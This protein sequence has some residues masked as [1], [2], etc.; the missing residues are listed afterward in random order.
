MSGTAYG[1]LVPLNQSE[2][3]Y[4]FGTVALPMVIFAYLFTVIYNSI[5]DSRA[6]IIEARK[7]KKMAKYYF[8]DLGVNHKL[9]NRLLNYLSYVYEKKHPINNEF[10]AEIPPSTRNEYIKTVIGVS[11]DFT[12]FYNISRPSFDLDMI[13]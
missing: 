4:T 8:T 12:I 7:Y 3:A 6:A 13:K 9:K 11:Y 1:D 5:S 10:I 2:T